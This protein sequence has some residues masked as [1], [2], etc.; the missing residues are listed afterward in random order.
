LGQIFDAART[1]AFYGEMIE[2]GGRILIKTPSPPADRV[3]P[4]TGTPLPNSPLD[5]YPR[6]RVLAVDR[7]WQTRRGWPDVVK[8]SAFRNRY[9]K[10][11]PMKIGAALWRA[12]IDVVTEGPERRRAA[13]PHRRLDAP[14]NAGR[15][16]HP[17][18]GLR[19]LPAHRQRRQPARDRAGLDTKKTARSRRA[20]RTRDLEMELGPKRR[21]T[22]E[23]KARAVIEAV[24]EEFAGGLDKVVLAFWHKDVGAILAEGLASSSVLSE[25]T[26]ARR[27]T[28]GYRPRRRSATTR[29]PA[30]FSRR[31]WRPARPSISAP[32]A[33]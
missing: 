23:I 2:D 6:L 17:P 4:L 26:A 16:W 19:D 22:G 10:W 14:A 3:W 28:N 29:R 31:S 7:Y 13:R 33:S 20:G 1:Q 9:C 11:H 32:P 15:C 25:L 27:P 30:C 24:K 8:F 21:L 12:W 5:A 18:A